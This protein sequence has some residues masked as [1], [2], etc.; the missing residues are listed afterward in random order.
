MENPKKVPL[1]MQI[2]SGITAAMAILMAYP[3]IM[4]IYHRLGFGDSIG[5]PH[6]AE[7]PLLLPL[8]TTIVFVVLSVLCSR[9]SRLH[10]KDQADNER[11]QA[12]G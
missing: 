3:T 10:R 12:D 6:W 2:G 4:I 9:P 1:P 7:M 8:V 11:I 5:P